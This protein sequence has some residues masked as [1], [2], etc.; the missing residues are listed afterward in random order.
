[1]NHLAHLVLAGEDEG[2]RLGALLGDHVKGRLALSALPPAWAR[3]VLL[4]RRIDAWSD[5]HP[6]LGRFL[7]RLDPPWRRYGGVI[8]DVLFDSV[9]SRHWKRF[10]PESMPDYARGIDALLARHAQA[11]PPRLALFAAWARQHRLWQRYDDRD[12]LAM[13]FQGLARRHGRKS[14][15]ASGLELL[16][17]H[18]QQI[19]RVFLEL[20]PD[21]QARAQSFR[22][23]LLK[24]VE[25]VG[26]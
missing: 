23:Q 9:L 16:D 3:G 19:E 22:E 18:E 2:L 8:S 21:L 5:R 11:L 25:H 24:H 20:F 13:I 12:M 15:L 6:A 1:M 17:R 4:H 14:P 7:E 26:D 10:G